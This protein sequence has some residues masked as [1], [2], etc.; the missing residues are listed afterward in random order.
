MSIA[1]VAVGDSSSISIVTG[2]S[3][4]RSSISIASIEFEDSTSISIAAGEFERL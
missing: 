1:K 4:G 3:E 2:G